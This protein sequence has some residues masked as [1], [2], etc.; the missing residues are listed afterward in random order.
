[1]KLKKADLGVT[2][3][4]YYQEIPGFQVTL[5]GTEEASSSLKSST[6]TLV[7]TSE[8]VNEVAPNRMSTTG[9]KADL[10][11]DATKAI[12]NTEAQGV[13]VS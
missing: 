5:T 9:N 12:W 10:S 7:I 6:S 3:S 13:S 1:M 2:L 4:D 8:Q 11:A